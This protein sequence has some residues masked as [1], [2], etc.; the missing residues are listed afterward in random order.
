MKNLEALQKARKT[1]SVKTMKNSE[2]LFHITSEHQVTLST[3]EELQ[4]TSK[5]STTTNGTV[6]QKYLHKTDSK[7]WLKMA[8]HTTQYNHA[9]YN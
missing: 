6:Q 8:V 1:F 5:D 9:G 2:E 7:S 3:S 4:F